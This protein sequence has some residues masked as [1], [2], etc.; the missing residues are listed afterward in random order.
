MTRKPDMEGSPSLRVLVLEDSSA[1]ARLVSRALTSNGRDIEVDLATDRGRFED[2]IASSTFDVILAD[3][4]MPG[5]DGLAALALAQA[6]SPFT[7]FICVS[8][9]IGEETTVD[10]LKQG[11]ADVVL[12]DKLARLPFAVE[13]AMAEAANRKALRE[14]EERFASL[15]I[16]APLGY[17]ALDEQGR[18]LD[19]NTAWLEALGYAREEVVGR[20]FEEF[21][22]PGSVEAFRER[23][24][25]F[26]KRGAID[27]RF[28]MIHKNGEKRA[29]AFDGRIGHKPDGSFA[30]THCI[31]TDVTESKRAEDALRESEAKLRAL[32]DS[33]PDLVWLKDPEGRYLACNRRFERFFGAAEGEILGKTD[34]DFVDAGLAVSFR[35]ND[36]AAMAAGAPT[37]NE[38]EVVF[39]ADGHK[40]TLETIKSPVVASDGGLVGVLGVGR[41]ITERRRAEEEVRLHAEQLQRTVEGAVLAMSHMAESR[42]PYTAGHERRVGELATAIGAEMGMTGRELDSLGLAGMIHD[43]GKIAVPAEILSKPGRLSETEFSLIQ[44]HPETGFDILSEID[45]GSPIAEIVLQHHERLDGSGYPR[46]LK[47]GEI[48]AEARILAVADVVEAMSSHRPYRA[49][50]GM[51]AALAEVREHV[52]VKFD[53]DVVATCV[54]LIEDE[55]FLFTP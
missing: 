12:K 41:D 15:F 47:G 54:R 40:E 46:G 21:L 20:R 24:E 22:T 5:F 31:L 49:A 37:V 33:L 32:I 45:F 7:P 6:A 43:I 25:V 13:R 4:S 14:S 16:E 34:F 9:T 52:G 19:V 38:E 53:A 30:Q 44:A 23:F 11:A 1:D 39:A 50:L 27:S 2:L 48:M 36:K 29:I 3:F 17:Q 8:G 28:E 26:K 55:G 10:L 42:D 18:F 51:E 35:R